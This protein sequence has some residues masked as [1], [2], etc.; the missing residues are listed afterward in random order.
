MRI[1]HTGAR[2][3]SN[4]MKYT[5]Q[6]SSKSTDA[7]SIHFKRGKLNIGIIPDSAESLPN[8]AEVFIG[9]LAACILKNVERFSEF[10][11]FQYSRAEVEINATRLEKPP[12]MDAI[13][14]QLILY[15]DDG[16]INT[17][18]L[19]KNLEKFGTIYNTVKLSCSIEGTIECRSDEVA[20]D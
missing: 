14:Y 7:A 12:R 19:K 5:I 20:A 4:S 13:E 10:M 1:Q 11:H 15:T 8:P 17:E 6:A 9:S 3:Q 18:L 2:K 16:N